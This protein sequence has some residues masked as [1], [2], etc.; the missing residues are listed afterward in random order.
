MVPNVRAVHMQTASLPRTRGDG[1]FLAPHLLFPNSF[2]PHTRG[3]SLHDYCMTFPGALCPAHAGM[4]RR[5]TPSQPSNAPLPRTR[6]D[7]PWV[8]AG[9]RDSAGFAP[10]T[11]GWSHAEGRASNALPLCPAHAGMVPVKR[12]R[13]FGTTALPR[14]RGDGP[15]LYQQLPAGMIFAP[16]ARGWSQESKGLHPCGDLCPAHAGMGPSKNANFW[17][18]TALPRTRGDGPK[19]ETRKE[20]KV[21]FAPHTRGWSGTSGA[22]FF[23]GELCFI[24]GGMQ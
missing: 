6:G 9:A 2:A 24:R 4:V 13:N 20:G 22:A 5:R 16:H 3:W 14:T 12:S 10:H 15:E 18:R 8:V 1:P 21:G 17:P 11:R 7:G 23:F 19:V